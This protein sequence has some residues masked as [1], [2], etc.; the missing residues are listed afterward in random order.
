[1]TIVKI[2]TGLH[3]EALFGNVLAITNAMRGQ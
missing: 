3:L 1:M 2:D